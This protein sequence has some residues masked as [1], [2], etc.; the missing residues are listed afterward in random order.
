MNGIITDI[1][2]MPGMP[3]VRQVNVVPVLPVAFPQR[4]YNM[5]VLTYNVGGEISKMEGLFA[6]M[7]TN[8]GDDTAH[9][10]GMVLFPSATPLTALGDS[11]TISGHLGDLY[12]GN[13]KL[14]FAGVGIAPGVEIVQL[15]YVQ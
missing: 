4:P 12:K 14:T 10:N 6:F 2:A 5:S 9:I 3:G 13:I 7:F 8:I 11:R 1:G 15:F